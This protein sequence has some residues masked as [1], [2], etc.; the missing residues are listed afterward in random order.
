MNAPEAPNQP[1]SLPPTAEQN[2]VH[3]ALAQLHERYAQ[4]YQAAGAKPRGD[5]VGAWQA[6]C[7]VGKP[8]G[9]EIAWQAVAQE[10]PLDFSG[11]EHGL[12]MALDGQVKALFSAFYA[13]DLILEHEGNELVLLQVMCAE[14]A[15]RLQKNLIAHVLMKQRL[16]Q[17]I[18][19]FIGLTDEDD[20]IIS[21]NNETGVV[22]LEY[23]GKEQ[24]QVLAE[25]VCEFLNKLTP[26]LEAT[27]FTA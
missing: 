8:S 15:E 7:Y 27:H 3:H 12:E 22:A 17:P 4:A 16:R 5:Y 24:H 26:K 25:N 6:P 21:V 19:L 13:G 1:Q 9:G 18:T 11:V 10:P 20:L 2:E 14:D 23:V